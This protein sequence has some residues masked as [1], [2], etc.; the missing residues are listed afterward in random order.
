M[1]TLTTDSGCDVLCHVR[2][3][4]W[5][6]PAGAHS[7]LLRPAAG[8]GDTMALYSQTGIL[9][10]GGVPAKPTLDH[11]VLPPVGSLQSGATET[12][13]QS[14]TYGSRSSLEEALSS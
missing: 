2:Q 4:P 10:S 14:T 13:L 12:G 3:S 5:C 9:G 7:L 11:H 8:T 1:T 6:G